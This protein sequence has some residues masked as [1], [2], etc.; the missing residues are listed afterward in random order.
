MLNW[1]KRILWLWYQC[2]VSMKNM[3]TFIPFLLY[4]AIQFFILV[5]IV[6]FVS[7]PVA[8][9]YIP[10][11][12]QLFGDWAL[13]YPSFF[14]I[15]TP[16]FNQINFLLSG[17]LGVVLI[18]MATSMF[19]DQFQSNQMSLSRAAQRTGNKYGILMVIWLIESILTM[20][21]VVGFPYILD[22]F[23]HLEY[24]VE[25]LTELIGLF[26]G[27]II[28]SLFAYTTALVMLSNCRLSE[29]LS[30][31]FLIFRKNSL[32]TFIL[33]AIPTAV[34]LPVSYIAGKANVIMVKFS[35]ETISIILGLGIIIS[36]FTNYFQINTITRLYLHVTD[37]NKSLS[38]FI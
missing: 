6:N 8:F 24:Q 17:L 27:I 32:T 5:S 11:I 28:T 4:A 34:Y 10:I 25:R 23:F 18:G 7:P 29:S 22:I 3:K 38:D 21:A 35:P 15:L 33:V 20:A 13:H 2:F 14:F 36:L 30:H 16:L 1:F 9:V 37:K 26:L 19:A 12:R 31:T